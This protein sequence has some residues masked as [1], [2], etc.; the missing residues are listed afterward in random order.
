MT[1]VMR[2]I[3][4]LPERV[5]LALELRWYYKTN[6]HIE[7]QQKVF[8]E[9]GKEAWIPLPVTSKDMEEQTLYC[10]E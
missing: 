4:G 6:T 3:D 7:L 1:F 2:V 9:S 10:K 5:M 8:R